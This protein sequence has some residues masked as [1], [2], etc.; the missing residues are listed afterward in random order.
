MI[1]TAWHEVRLKNKLI[2]AVMAVHEAR[3]ALNRA[4]NEYDRLYREVERRGRWNQKRR[5]SRPEEA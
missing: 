5:K 1:Q 4:Q 2:R 3:M